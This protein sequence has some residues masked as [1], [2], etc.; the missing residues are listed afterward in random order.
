MLRRWLV[1]AAIAIILFN[2]VNLAL[3]ALRPTEEVFAPPGSSYG[4]N[5]DATLAWDELLGAL[6][7]RTTRLEQPLS[8]VQLGSGRLGTDDTLV[9]MEPGFWQPEPADIDR[10]QEFLEGEVDW[11][12]VGRCRMSSSTVFLKY[13][14]PT[15]SMARL[16]RQFWSEAR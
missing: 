9:I 16:R 5:A 4:T 13:H 7:F 3:R 15:T 11:C 2:L 1:G 8:T 10:L 14:Q 12:S 6:G